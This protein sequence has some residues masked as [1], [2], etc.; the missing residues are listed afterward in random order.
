MANGT[1]DLKE[2]RMT[3]WEEIGVRISSSLRRN[4]IVLPTNQDIISAAFL[5]VVI[6][7][8]DGFIEEYE[9][10]KIQK[11]VDKSIEDLTLKGYLL[12]F[13]QKYWPLIHSVAHSYPLE[14]LQGV[15]FFYNKRNEL[16][17]LPDGVMSLARKVANIQPEDIVIDFTAGDG[18]FLLKLASH[19]MPKKMYAVSQTKEIPLV[20]KMR[21]MASEGMLEIYNGDWTKLKGTKLFCW[22]PFG[23]KYEET[24]IA[25][26]GMPEKKMRKSP[27]E[28]ADWEK[29]ATILQCQEKGGLTVALM[30]E[31]ALFS[32][33]K[34]DRENRQQ[35][36]ERE[37]L[38]AVITLL[39]GA[40]GST[41]T[42]AALLILSNDNQ[43]VRLVDTTKFARS[44]M[45]YTLSTEKIDQILTFLKQDAANSC[46]VSN[47]EM[48]K[49]NSSWLPKQYFTAKEEPIKNGVRLRQAVISLQRGYTIRRQMLEEL[50]STQ[51][52]PYRYLRLQDLQDGQIQDSMLYLTELSREMQRAVISSGDLILTR[53]EPFKAAVFTGGSEEQVVANGNLFY[54]QLDNTQFLPVYVMLYLN[55]PQGQRQ[56]ENKA[57]GSII[58]SLS[59]KELENVE[60]PLRPLAEQEA[61]VKQYEE[62]LNQLNE[63]KKQENK[64]YDK[65]RKLV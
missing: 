18:S 40:L 5:A 21:E 22:L 48:I 61:I 12:N 44:G 25:Y 43:G 47:E 54:L 63:L 65:L 30:S 4:S 36:L 49:N 33:L 3:R 28:R 6:H 27:L 64:I 14:A 15:V 26:T 1:I 19:T 7:K 56:L 41:L 51:P 24:K 20:L 55:S 8:E 62:Y 37:Q 23:T 39:P 53:N 9:M 16:P 10:E 50:V 17:T 42:V 34:R 31:A 58:Q 38:Q 57:A 46:F 29:L 32:R 59:R 13:L 45:R 52:T 60:I 11:A 35:V 2:I